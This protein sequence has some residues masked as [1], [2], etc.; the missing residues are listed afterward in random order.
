MVDVFLNL[1]LQCFQ[2]PPSRQQMNV[3]MPDRNRPERIA[4]RIKVSYADAALCPQPC[5]S[6]HT[7]CKDESSD[8]IPSLLSPP[9]STFFFLEKV[10]AGGSNTPMPMKHPRTLLAVL[11]TIL[12]PPTSPA[13]RKLPG[14]LFPLAALPVRT[15]PD[16]SAGIIFAA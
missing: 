5:H 3:L 14:E 12:C 6:A 4:T 9:F 15:L 16:A 10:S 1:H 13:L 2:C 8:Y 7:K 11:T